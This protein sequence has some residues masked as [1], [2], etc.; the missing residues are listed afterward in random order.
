MTAEAHKALARRVREEFISTGDM[1]VADAVLAEDFVYHGPAML[2]EIRGRAAFKEAIAGF[3]E[4][5]PELRERV[6]EQ[7][8]DGDRVCSR[9]TTAL[10][11]DWGLDIIRIA[12]GKVVEM[13]AMFDSLRLAQR[14][15]IVPA[16]AAAQSP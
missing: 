1:A 9:F 2:P 4:A 3:R 13:W 11:G 14:L 15:G 5:M 6:A 10:E 16:D 7:Y 12:D 8:V